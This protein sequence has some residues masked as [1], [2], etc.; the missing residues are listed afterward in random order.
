MTYSTFIRGSWVW[1]SDGSLGAYDEEG[2][3]ISPIAEDKMSGL[4]TLTREATMRLIARAPEMY[5]LL[6]TL[7][8]NLKYSGLKKK[9]RA[10]VRDMLNTID[11]GAFSQTPNKRL[12]A[13]AHE[14]FSE[15]FS[16]VNV[17]ADGSSY[18]DDDK[19][20]GNTQKIAMDLIKAID[21]A[22]IS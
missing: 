6:E 18:D 17:I 20:G 2:R 21:G 12:I 4:D 16:F 1:I 5:H 7:S 14:L 13:Y 3:L 11:F 22:D 9:A 19:I 8:R 15:L 10:D